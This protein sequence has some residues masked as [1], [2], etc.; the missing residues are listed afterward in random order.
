MRTYKFYLVVITALLVSA[1]VFGQTKTE[2]FK[3]SGNCGMCESRIET[4][5]KDVDGVTSAD[6]DKKT[7]KIVVTYDDT[8]TSLEAIHK[9]IANA[10]YDTEKEKADEKTYNDLPKCCQYTRGSDESSDH[11]HHN[12]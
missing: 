12:H 4:A 10:G 1:A 11:S 2:T 7:K 8:K 9:A 5:A 3:V 6:W